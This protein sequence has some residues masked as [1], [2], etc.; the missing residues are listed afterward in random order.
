MALQSSTS[1]LNAIF[2]RSSLQ[3]DG[4][5]ND[6]DKP[7]SATDANK[8]KRSLQFKSKY[9]GAAS[10]QQL[11][12]EK[13]LENQKRKRM[14]R[15]A[16]S[17]GLNVDLNGKS[18]DKSDSAA[19]VEVV[20]GGGSQ[21]IDSTP[22]NTPQT[23]VHGSVSDGAVT[24]SGIPLVG[25]PE[26]YA[27]AAQQ[28]QPVH[29]HT[30]LVASATLMDIPEQATGK[31]ELMDTSDHESGGGDQNCKDGDK[32][33]KTNKPRQMKDKLM[34]SEWMREVPLDLQSEW[35][36]TVCP[37]GRRTLVIAQRGVTSA[38]RR[39]G[40]LTARFPSSLPAGSRRQGKHNK[41]GHC[42]QII[43]I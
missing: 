4:S 39:N 5:Q 41:G 22:L 35:T 3:D 15:F 27:Q 13:F 6:G 37:K 20:N 29:D 14:D 30:V 33:T 42:M 8:A 1:S 17:R 38:Y 32:E 26:L 12:R 10:A 16:W 43:Q 19:L 36:F 31:E 11:R 23:A 9:G 24:Q 21:T 28:H 7:I 25:L 2:G 40:R 18:G 34:L